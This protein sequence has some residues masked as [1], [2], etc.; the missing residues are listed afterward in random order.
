MLCVAVRT[1]IPRRKTNG[2]IE[3]EFIHP[4]EC[5][6]GI[7]SRL[8]LKNSNENL[9]CWLVGDIRMTGACSVLYCT[10]RTVRMMLWRLLKVVESIKFIRI[11]LRTTYVQ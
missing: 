11:I 9:V 3:I 5:I 7:R 10:V 2:C 6:M 8:D 4:H 1:K